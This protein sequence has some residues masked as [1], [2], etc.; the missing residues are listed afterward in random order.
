V[1]LG[2]G[3]HLVG[4]LNGVGGAGNEWRS[5]ALRDVA[6][7]D[8]VAKG[9]DG[10]GARADPRQAGVDDRLSELRVLREESVAG[11]HGLGLSALRD[12]DDLG[13]VEVCLSRCGAP[14]R[15]RVVGEPDVGRVAVRIRVDGDGA[16]PGILARTNDANC[17]LSTVGDEHR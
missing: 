15:E 5:G 3:D 17:D 4:R 7:A 10:R 12:I 9:L 16:Q 13:D 8:L 1:L 6:R 14:Q 2:K 11:V